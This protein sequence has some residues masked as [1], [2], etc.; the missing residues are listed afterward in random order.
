MGGSGMADGNYKLIEEK[1]D[2]LWFD[3]SPIILSAWRLELDTKTG[4]MFASG[5]FLNVQPDN[6]RSLT[7]DVICYD[8]GRNLIDCISGFSFNGLDVSRN[9]DFGYNRRLPINDINTRSVEFVIREVQ[10]TLGQT[11]ENK[12]NKRFDKIIEQRSI[13]DVQGDYNKQFLRLCS[14]SGIDGTMLVFEPL[15][16]KNYWL[17]ACGSFNWSDE[18]VCSQCHVGRSWLEKNTRLDVLEDQKQRQATE[19][20][21]MI[22][23]IQSRAN[24]M[25]DKSAEK[26]EFKR[27]KE[28]YE[29]QQKKQKSKKRTK[30]ILIVLLIA[31]AV[32]GICY[33][34]F[35]FAIPYFRYSDAVSAMQNKQYDKALTTFQNLGDF[36]DSKQYV[37]QCQ[38]DKA[39]DLFRSGKYEEAAEIFKSISPFSDSRERYVTCLMTYADNLKE[40]NK[41]D[42]Y[43]KAADLYAKLGNQSGA[44]QKLEECLEGLYNQGLYYLNKDGNYVEAAKNFE[45]LKNHNYKDAEEKLNESRYEQAKR[46]M[47]RYFYARALEGLKACNGFKD[48]AEL[49]KNNMILAALISTADDQTPAKWK[50]DKVNCPKCKEETASFS[51][52]FS[53]MGEM[54]SSFDCTKH[55]TSDKEKQHR[56]RYK[57]ENNMIRVIDY[58]GKKIWIDYAKIYSLKQS[59]SGTGYEFVISNPMEPSERLTLYGT[60]TQ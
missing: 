10:N 49:I 27:R 22:A 1:T 32:A 59:D 38:Y 41:K 20:Q 24:Q 40:D 26:E 34:V 53:T 16:Q 33:G 56:Y 45:Y 2:S 6:L 23:E 44:P 21:Q 5:K 7:F 51:L 58:D 48:S 47:S 3:G 19:S 18:R 11:W 54:I 35:G 8:E 46:D 39:D 31:L 9:A 29:K 28:I 25:D 17:C 4:E 60:V 55:T 37:L 12:K 36:M 14:R 42:N 50:N 13:Y 57:I 52:T 30:V 43:I 15:F